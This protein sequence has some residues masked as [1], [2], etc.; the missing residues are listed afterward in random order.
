MNQS[1][2]VANGLSPF[3][4]FDINLRAL[5]SSELLHLVTEM[6]VV[7]ELETRSGERPQFPW[8]ESCLSKPG[9]SFTSSSFTVTQAPSL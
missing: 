8:I 9:D 5:K 3:T 1:A 4:R 7:F 2:A 6:V